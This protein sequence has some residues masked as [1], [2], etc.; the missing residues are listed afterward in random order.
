MIYTA[1]FEHTKEKKAGHETAHK[2][3]AFALSEEYGLEYQELVMEKGPFGK[4]YLKDYP[5][6]HF[7]ISHC[8]GMTA[9]ILAGGEAGIDIE[10][11]RPYHVRIE[12]KALTE[13]EAA[14]L[15]HSSKKEEIFFRFWTLKESYIKAIGKGLSCPLTDVEF[16][17]PDECSGLV[18]SN[19]RDWI[20]FQQKLKGEY[21]L[22]ACVSARA[23]QDRTTEE[24]FKLF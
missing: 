21:I 15:L 1:S 23:F 2:L 18:E 6:V 12:K 24:C 16:T 4:P 20:F 17:L 8:D 19:Q 11:I 10:K 13:K 7:N 5:T 22:S 14:V 3:L 9:C